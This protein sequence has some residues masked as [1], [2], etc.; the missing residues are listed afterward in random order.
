MSTSKQRREN[1]WKVR[2]QSQHP[3][4]KITSLHDLATSSP[5]HL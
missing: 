2:K 5:K 1:A 4:R 3:H